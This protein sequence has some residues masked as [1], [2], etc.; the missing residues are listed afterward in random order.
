M[1]TESDVAPPTG[2]PKLVVYSYDEFCAM[3]DKEPKGWRW[4]Q[5]LPLS[6]TALIVGP[7]FSGKSTLVAVLAAG[8]RNG[9]EVG[10]HAVRKGG[11]VIAFLEHTARDFSTKLRSAATAMGIAKPRVKIVRELD[12]DDPSQVAQLDEIATNAKARVIVIDSFRRSTRADENGS[13]D[14]SHYGKALA[15]L[16][17]NGERLVIA[18]HH[19]GKNGDIR[20]STDFAAMVDS[21]VRVSRTG[22]MMTLRATHHNAAEFNLKLR[23]RQD[24]ARI[25]V[26]DG[27]TTASATAIIQPEL[28][29]LIFEIVRDAPGITARKIRDAVRTT[30][31]RTSHEAIK[32][33]VV[34]LLADGTIENRGSDKSHA[35]YV[36]ERK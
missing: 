24:D 9:D 27:G 35:Y 23:V 6:G 10:G 28:R 34:E 15:Q 29:T 17:H 2:A 14:V 26:E 20:G 3:G 25:T 13:Q 32:R 30:K 8:M 12:L 4:D 5:L 36:V 22:D 1:T 31:T 7:A 16:T 19:P 11:M 33:V 21:V 18:I